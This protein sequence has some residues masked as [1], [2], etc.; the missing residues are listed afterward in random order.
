[1]IHAALVCVLYAL[2][3]YMLCTILLLAGTICY[4]FLVYFVAFR[5]FNAAAVYMPF[6]IKEAR[7]RQ[8]SVFSIPNRTYKYVYL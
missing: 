4:C 1:M 8:I 7:A 2:I 3:A 5:N 6:A